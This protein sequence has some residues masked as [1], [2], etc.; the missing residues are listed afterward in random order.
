M[1]DSGILGGV[2]YELRRGGVYIARDSVVLART[3]S[4]IGPSLIGPGTNLS[5]KTL[6]KQSTLGANNF[7]GSQS[8]VEGSYLFDNVR[9]G[10]G[11]KLE[12]CIVAEDVMIEDNVTVGRGALIGSGVILGK[13]TIIRPFD[14]IGK[15]PFK[16]NDGFDDED[17][18]DDEDNEAYE[19]H[20]L[21]GAGSLGYL[22]PREDEATNSDDDEDDIED[23]YEHPDNKRL[24]Q[25]GR[26][27]S[28]VSIASTSI[29]TLSHASTSDAG[30]E[31]SAAS[32]GMQ[33]IPSLSMGVPSD[34][35]FH[36]EARLS[37]E[38][39]W[40]EGHRIEDALLELK[41]LMLSSNVGVS[42]PRGGRHEVVTFLMEKVDVAKGAKETKKASEEVW[43][44]WGGIIV[45]MGG[46]G[47]ETVL[48]VQV[49]NHSGDDFFFPAVIC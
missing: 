47:V 8:T 13:G 22:W 11:C 42:G 4:V 44:R 25:L 39:A 36:V 33:S 26:S 46:D 14:R 30:S 5:Q 28:N 40:N 24:L 6:V 48:A 17:D 2:D 49:C 31:H 45:G 3:A 35:N 12:G 10:K 20:R 37:L 29:S 7:L 32:S 1:P 34:S 23:P 38:R 41:T 16:E 18:E 9:V 43:Q 27:L 19:A 15:T 21:Q